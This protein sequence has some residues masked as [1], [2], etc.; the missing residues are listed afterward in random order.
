MTEA[1][2]RPAADHVPLDALALPDDAKEIRQQRTGIALMVASNGLLAIGDATAKWLSAT[3]PVGEIIFLRGL[4]ILALLVALQ[5]RSGLAK[6]KPGDLAG[7][8]RRAIFFVLATFLMIWSLSLLPLPTV[9]AISFAAPIIVTA[10]APWLL[11]EI[12]GRQRWIAVVA[13]FLGVL[14][15]AAP[16]G[17]SWSFA[18]LIPLAAAVAMALRDITTRQ[19][20]E[21]ETSESVVFVTVGATVLAAAPTL[22]F[23]FVAPSAWDWGLFLFLG[24]AQGCAYLMQVGAFRAAEAAFLAPFKYSLLIWA[25]VVAFVVWGH[26]PDL[27]VFVGAGII[28]GSGIVIWYREVGPR[29]QPASSI[30][31]RAARSMHGSTK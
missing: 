3:Y 17:A 27:A 5:S 12:A 6:L 16:L 7:Q 22:P 1:T 2:A 13:G 29:A 31:G 18:L 21:T 14:L 9:S 23:G 8:L 20:V 25:I 26:I 30:A 15:I 10:L 24:A 28:V 11:G 4:I 19:V